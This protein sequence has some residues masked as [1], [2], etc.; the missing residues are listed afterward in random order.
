M[1]EAAGNT[2]ST[3]QLVVREGV[4]GNL[5]LPVDSEVLVVGLIARC[6]YCCHGSYVCLHN[7]TLQCIAGMR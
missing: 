2:S 1:G 7:A 4:G 3:C 5:L 6:G